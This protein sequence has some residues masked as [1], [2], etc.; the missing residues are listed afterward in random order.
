MYFID[1]DILINRIPNTN[2]HIDV[3]NIKVNVE[4]LRLFDFINL[5]NFPY[6]FFSF[7]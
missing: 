3:A 4:Q 1:Q 2:R 6:S 7:S 5:F